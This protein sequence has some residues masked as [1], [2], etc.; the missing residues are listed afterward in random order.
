MAVAVAHMAYGW[1]PAALMMCDVNQEIKYKNKK[2]ILCI[3]GA[4]DVK[5]SGDARKFAEGFASSPKEK[6]WYVEKA[7]KQIFEKE[8]F[9]SHNIV[10]LH[11][12]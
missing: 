5:T 7:Q 12:G 4:F 3:V 11:E 8:C 2:A 6:P 9:M 10:Y 1:M